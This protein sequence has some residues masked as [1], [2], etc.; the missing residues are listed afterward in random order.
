M[1]IWIII[2]NHL[3]VQEDA[4]V[5]HFAAEEIYGLLDM[6][7]D[8]IIDGITVPPIRNAL[9]DIHFSSIGSDLS[10]SVVNESDSN[11]CNLKLSCNRYGAEVEVDIVD[12]FI[13][14]Q[15]VFNDEW[16][17][18]SGNTVELNLL[19]K[20]LHICN[21]G[22]LTVIQ[23]IGILKNQKQTKSELIQIHE[24]A[25]GK[26]QVHDDHA[27]RLAGLNAKLYPYQ[28]DGFLWM[29]YI[30]SEGAGCI[31]ADE[32][33]LGKTLQII[34]LILDRKVLEV[35]PS[36][37]IAPVSLLENWKREIRRFAPSLKTL[38]HHGSKRTGLYKE[39][40]KY[41]TVIISYATAVSDASLLGMLEWDLVVL[42]EAQNIKNPAS[43]RSN[44]VRRIRR[45]I[46]IAVTG[47]PFE[48]HVS[49]VWSLV[50]FV[51]PGSLGSLSEF[52]GMVSD[53]LDGAM[54]LEPLISPILLRRKVVDVAQE[55]PEKVIIT[56]PIVMS[57][58]ESA[59]Y[60][61]LRQA[62]SNSTDPQRLSL[63]S[64]Q[65]L[66]MYCTHPCLC[67]GYGD[68]DC[69]SESIKYQRLCEILE[70][71][72]AKNEKVL[73]F[74]SF[75]GMLNLLEADIVKRYDVPVMRIDGSTPV[76][77]RQPIVDSFNQSIGA[78]LLVLNPRAA[79]TGLNIASAN[80][81][82]HYNPEWNPAV[83]D[84]ASAR[85]YRRGQN[86]TVFIYRFYYLNTV[87][88]VIN[89]R[90]DRKRDMSEVAIIGTD[91]R[92]ENK[93]DLLRALAV[94]PILDRGK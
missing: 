46:G 83:E 33:G 5:L 53:D 23:Y 67:S 75:T 61:E 65:R 79:G 34:A 11:D 70:E 88:E 19:F 77:D 74:T 6:S 44:F 28:L 26:H 49:D 89:E 7:T 38:I 17:Y 87:E 63:G 2:N 55:L 76:T 31:L 48:N 52:T 37:V 84:Q 40:L 24:I 72:F 80:H 82:I 59:R 93:N 12:G 20:N 54:T 81:V 36:L 60:E 22:R 39:L 85:A 68:T 73:V 14:D 90:I 42:D 69:F 91:G 3:A 16:F 71:I 25:P 29:K 58:F 18:I 1:G 94:S 4:A 64:I 30:L 13:V 86:R 92:F 51:L 57:D 78:G 32:M 66:R 56:Q 47:T 10:C 21:S 8:V 9:P 27:S 50:D 35:N 41:D 15:C 45:R 62:I 43:D